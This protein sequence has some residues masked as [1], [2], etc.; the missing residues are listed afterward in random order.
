MSGAPTFGDL[1][2]EQ[3]MRNV[4]DDDLASFDVLY[5]R[6][7]PSSLR[8]AHGICHSIERAEDAV[9][10]AFLSV[11]RGRRMY[12]PTRGAVHSWVFQIVRFSA[13]DLARHRGRENSRQEFASPDIPEAVAPDDLES[14]VERAD[15]AKRIREMLARLPSDQAEVIKRAFFAQQSHSEIAAQLDLPLGTV[16]GRMRLGYELLRTQ[17][18]WVGAPVSGDPGADANRNQG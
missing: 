10:E 11:W 2:N 5:S 7:S 15:E 4:K 18:D 1:T 6:L 9:Q 14:L 8:V 12:E 16:K 17:V 3:L 13:I